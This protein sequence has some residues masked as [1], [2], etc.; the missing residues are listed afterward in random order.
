[1][2]I[3]AGGEH[4]LVLKEDGT[5]WAWGWYYYGQLGV[6]RTPVQVLGL[7]PLI[8]NYFNEHGQP[9]NNEE[10]SYFYN[11]AE[12]QWYRGSKGGQITPIVLPPWEEQNAP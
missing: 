1:L 6:V 11:E 12:K 9:Y 2:A 4:S 5:V 7:P 8:I 3:A 10:Y